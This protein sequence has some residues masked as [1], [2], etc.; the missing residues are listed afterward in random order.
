MAVPLHGLSCNAE[1][2]TSGTAASAAK[3]QLLLDLA[4]RK[5]QDAQYAAWI[6]PLA[7]AQLLNAAPCAAPHLWLQARLNTSLM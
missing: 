3:A 4:A 6:L 5:P 1:A 7:A 2:L